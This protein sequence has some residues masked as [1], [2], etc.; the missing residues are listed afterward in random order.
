MVRGLALALA[1][2]PLAARADIIISELCDPR[3]NYA[4]DRFLEVYNTGDQAVDLAGWR[5]VAVANNVDVLAWD[6]SGLIDAHQALVAG[7]ATTVV[8]FPV[9]FADEAWSGANGNWN[10]KVG[11]GA[12]LVD[13][14]GATVD[15]VVAT[16][17]AF[18]NADYVRNA[19]VTA[20]S[21]VYVVAQWHATAVDLAT[22]ATPGTHNGGTP[23]QGPVV[24]SIVTDPLAPVAGDAVHIQAAV[25]DA[26]A[27]VTQVAVNW[28]T[29]PT[30]LPNRIDMALVS[31]DIY[32]TITPVPAQSGGST[33]YFRV[34]ATNDI[35]AVTT[36]ALKQYSLPWSLAIAEIQGAAAASPYDGAMVRTQGVVTGVFGTTFTLQSGEGPWSGLWV[37]G[38]VMP[39]VGDL[40][41]VSGRVTESDGAAN[42]GNT[43]LVDAQVLGSV[44]GSP[45]PAPA[46]LATADCG[47]EAWEGVLVHV[48]ADCT[49]TDAGGGEWLLD[50]G[51]GACR[52]GR[53]GPTFTPVLGSTYAVAGPLAYSSGAFKIEPRSAADVVWTGDHAAPVVISVV[54]LGATTL[55][56]TFSEAVEPGSVGDTTHFAIP[57]LS[58]LAAARLATNPARVVLIVSAMTAGSYDLTVT[59]VADLFGNAA[60]GVAAA[61]DYF[62]PLVPSGYYDQA[63]GLAGPAL[64]AALHGIIRGHAAHSYDYAWTAYQTTDVR[65]DNGKVW[66]IYSDIPGGVPPYLYDF[67]VDE[68]GIGGAE[69]TGYTREHT[70]CKNWFGGAVSPMYTDLFTLFPCDTHMNGT[71]GVN[72]YGETAA[73]VFVSLNGSK[74][75]PSAVPGFTGTVFEPR[76]DF[77]GDLARAYMYF[78][79]RYYSEDAGW[80]GGP[81]TA[82]AALLPWAQDLYVQWAEQDPV[83]QK[84]IDRNN[85]IYAIQG[86]RNPFVDHPE[87]VPLVYGGATSGVGD[88]LP[89]DL[90]AQAPLTLRANPNPFNPRTVFTFNLSRPGPVRLAIY[91]LRG[92]QVALLVD[93]VRPEGEQSASWDGLDAR[94]SAAP[95]GIYFAQL[96]TESGKSTVKITLAR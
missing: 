20:G 71:R 87:Y 37:R 33:V 78:S 68:G 92:A 13:S 25:T 31:G 19:D 18:E 7:D 77:K 57:G 23:A 69:G 9:A 76:D 15:L 29:G 73:P 4:S 35:P 51:G 27:T 54:P 16:G 59:G 49:T 63:A 24:T 48:D 2:V 21:P 82:G 30:S 17:T 39:S 79:T 55:R 72:P 61:F 81:A 96:D 88:P 45:L 40:L 43:M 80:P 11:D 41:T 1:L 74:L 8:A 58:V 67:G 52:I 36:S 46:A 32:R 62:D 22:Q 65:P 14:S 42:T 56:V 90:P 38:A 5:L 95:S 75:G 64:Q 84:E 91:D 70:W 85:A 60:N 53:L 50:D 34:E 6:L 89:G 93:G 3:L 83:S 66:D 44:P 86:N 28:G 12:R 10:G 26:A 94:L 47:Q